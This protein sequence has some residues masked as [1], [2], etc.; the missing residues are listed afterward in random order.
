MRK[1]L[2]SVGVLIVAALIGYSSTTAVINSNEHLSAAAFKATS[3]SKG[4]YGYKRI[5]PCSLYQSFIVD[6]TNKLMGA[7]GDVANSIANGESQ[8]SIQRNKDRRN[9]LRA[10][11]NEQIALFN[12]C[13]KQFPL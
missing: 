3:D 6:I 12:K 9:E 1:T 11:L 4:G 13:R 5:D 8:E 10:T 7:N 2:I